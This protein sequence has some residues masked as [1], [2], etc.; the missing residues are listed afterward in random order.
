MAE[1]VDW[2]NHRCLHG[3][4]GLVPLAEFED[5]FYQ[6]GSVSSDAEALVPSL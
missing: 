3:E 1:Y 6:Q 2:F 4:I 5:G